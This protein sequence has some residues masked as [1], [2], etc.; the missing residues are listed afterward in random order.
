MA[1]VK[2]SVIGYLSG[3]LGQLSARTIKGRTILAARPASFKV[4]YVPALVEIRKKFANTVAFAKAM[5]SLSALA[6]V[7]KAKNTGNLSVFNYVFQ[8]NFDHSSA[9]KPTTSN[10]ITPDGFGTPVQSAVL[11]ADTITVELVALN[12]RTL[13]SPDERVLSINGLVCYYNP[14]DPDDKPYEII[15][16]NDEVE[17]FDFELPYTF[18]HS[19]DVLQQGI[20]A[21]YQGSIIYFA[22]VSKGIDGKIYQHSDTYSL[23]S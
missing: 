4:S 21:K 3:K 19:L 20:A 23:D 8:N 12:T 5:L 11:T 14:V 16:F 1:V 2:G 17:A 9:D 22:V 10:I 13:I 18:T 15:S 6:E 7:W